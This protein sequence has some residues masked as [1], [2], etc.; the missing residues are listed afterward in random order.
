MTPIFEV[1]SLQSKGNIKE[2]MRRYFQKG[3]ILLLVLSFLFLAA[4]ISELF[5][6]SPSQTAVLVLFE[7]AL[8]YGFFFFLLHR[9]TKLT[10]QRILVQNGGQETDIILRFYEDH[11]ETL[12]PI[13]GNRNSFSYGTVKKVWQTKNLYILVLSAKMYASV[14][15]ARFSVGD[16]TEF[17]A[18][19]KSRNPAVKF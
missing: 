4:F 17:P 6:R 2:V 5:S 18:F 12:N 15:K 16:P 1:Y 7:F 8:L 14:E 10:Y 3:F 19:I 9:N 11:F 13:S